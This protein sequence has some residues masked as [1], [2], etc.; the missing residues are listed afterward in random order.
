MKVVASVASIVL[1]FAADLCY[2]QSVC[3]DYPPMRIR[4]LRVG[5]W[6]CDKI[7]S[8]TTILV[9]GKTLHFKGF[10]PE[11]PVRG[12]LR[13]AVDPCTMISV[14]DAMDSFILELPRESVVLSRS[15]VVAVAIQATGTLALRD[16]RMF[17]VSVSIPECR[18]RYIDRQTREAEAVR[19]I[20][21]IRASAARSAIPEGARRDLHSR[22]SRAITNN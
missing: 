5:L 6:M 7:P 13:R 19:A 1:F 18:T 22:L 21:S 14:S 2:S 11:T 3:V 4:R 10:I 17:E 8:T 12:I 16:G 20:G 15:G 9:D